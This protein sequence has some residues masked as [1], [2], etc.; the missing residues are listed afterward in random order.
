[1]LSLLFSIGHVFKCTFDAEED[2]RL[3]YAP[4][5]PFDNG[6]FSLFGEDTRQP[7]RVTFDYSAIGDRSKDQNSCP[8]GRL[9]DP[10]GQHDLPPGSKKREAVI[11]TF[12]NVSAYIGNLVLVVPYNGALRPRAVFAKAFQDSSWLPIESPD[13]DLYIVVVNRGFEETAS[14]LAQAVAM[15]SNQNSN[16]L[17]RPI[18][19][20]V[21][22][23]AAK[24]DFE[25]PQS[26]DSGNRQFFITAVHELM[27]VLAFSSSSF[28]NWVDRTTKQPY[29]EPVVMLVNAYGLLQKFIV[30]PN[31]MRWVHERFQVVNEDLSRLGLELE[32]GGRSGTADSH[33]NSRLYFTDV[34]QGKTY[35]PGYISPIFQYSL[36]DSGWY[37]TNES[38]IEQLVYMNAKLHRSP[39]NQNALV[40]PA[41]LAFPPDYLCSDPSSPYFCYYDYSAKGV[42]SVAPEDQVL[43]NDPWYSESANKTRWYNPKGSKVVGSEELIDYAPVL[44][45]SSLG[46]CQNPDMPKIP[47]VKDLQR[48]LHETFEPSSICV[49]STIFNGNFGEMVFEPLPACFRAQCDTAGRLWLELDDGRKQLCTQTGKKIYSTKHLGHVK[50]PPALE[51]CANHKKFEVIPIIHAIPDRGPYDGKN[52]ILLTGV[53]LS[54]YPGLKID[55]GGIELPCLAKVDTGILC[56]FPDLGD[57]YRSKVMVPL[58]LNATD[59]VGHP[60]IPGNVTGFYSF[61]ARAYA[62]GWTMA[63]PGTI[64]LLLAVVTAIFI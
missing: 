59:E 21:T 52:L 55:I 62:A 50:C 46:L 23:N 31:L 26:M 22:V 19:G 41:P 6:D 7:I 27:H 3:R 32:D 20:L 43:K 8:G 11:G 60:G 42:C 2:R 1:M 16:D 39:P 51:A 24:V 61:T 53:K 44:L 63:A 49:M 56:Q 15:G 58:D 64:L 9:C 5:V 33:P 45:P 18:Y 12:N 30:T 25:T 14:T 35:G 37:D 13:C 34:M 47:D 28:P 17:G 38:F 29:T 48:K 57:R 54:D 4:P 36:I 10:G 40:Q